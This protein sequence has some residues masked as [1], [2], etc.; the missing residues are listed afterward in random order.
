MGS[1]MA[2]LLAAGAGTR[3]NS[4]IAKA[5]HKICGK[6]MINWVLDAIRE[7]GADETIVV[8]G[9]QEEQVRACVTGNAAFISQTEQ[10]G[11]GHALMQA[12]PLLEQKKGICVVLY[13]DTPLITP[14]TLKNFI[15]EH[16]N[17]GNAMTVLSAV[18]DDPSGYGRI[19]RD[20]QGGVEAI[21]EHR[22]LNREQLIIREINT[23]IYCFDIEWLLKALQVLSNQNHQGKYY[24]TDALAIIMMMGG[25]AGTV[26]LE[27]CEEALG[28]KDR[29]KLAAAQNILN[30]R[31]IEKHMRNG[32]TFLNPGSC[33]VEDGVTIGRDTIIYPSTI[34]EGSTSIRENCVIGP[35]TTLTD[36]HVGAHVSVINSVAKE[37]SIGDGAKIGPFAYIRPGSTIGKDVKIGDF[38]EIKKSNI[39]DDTKIS[40]LTYVGDAEIGKNVNMGCGVVVVNYDGRTKHKTVVGDNSFIGC[41]V[42]LVS[43]VE[44]K[45]NAYIAAGSTIT[46][47]VPEYSLAIARCRQT[48][49][50][51]WVIRKDR[52]RGTQKHEA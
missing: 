16:R 3:M 8:T 12:I 30:R 43:P 1:F 45:P 37:S 51:D 39:G 25:K 20:S 50:E 34:L 10:L 7:S 18:V 22:D 31:I 5:A 14:E 44:V 19:I 33:I 35:N 42:N 38:V 36:V 9:C 47:E 15:A 24:L 40:H 23:G 29:V 21:V 26:P 32:V 17:C 4:E 28:V 49:I 6:P 48:I 2:V 52:V 13:G 11:T 46:D 27:Y 41:N